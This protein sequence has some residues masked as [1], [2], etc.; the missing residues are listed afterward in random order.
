VVGARYTSRVDFPAYAAQPDHELDLLEGALLIAKDA[1]PGLDPST[2]VAQL[3][4]LAAPLAHRGLSHLP[5]FVQ[6]RALA[7]QLFVHAGFHGNTADYYDPKNSFLDEVLSRR[8]G[9]PISL[10]VVYVEVARRVGVRA[11]PV[12]FPGH[13]LVR[14]DDKSQR[15]LVI[16]PFHGGTILTEANLSDLLQRAGSSLSYDEGLIA[17]MPVRHVIARMLMN[18]RG[19]YSMRAE[20]ARLLVIFDRLIDLLPNSSEELRDRGFLFARLG[21]PGAAV[22]DLRRYLERWPDAEDAEAVER[23]MSRIAETAKRGTPSS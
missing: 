6:A 22:S 7:D 18:L 12:G 5:A 17:P 1:R 9:I 10:S 13:F 21:A 19:I 15:R 16:D 20:H 8:T 23:W 14:I 3:D 2:V 4:A 11:S